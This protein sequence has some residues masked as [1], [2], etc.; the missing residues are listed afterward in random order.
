M[1][2]LI[3]VS[4]YVLKGT[5][6]KGTS[7]LQNFLDKITRA[8][9]CGFVIYGLDCSKHIW[10]HNDSREMQFLGKQNTLKQGHNLH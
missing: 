6:L 8:A 5:R 4:T 9:A 3:E 2:N 10:L 7:N 1:R